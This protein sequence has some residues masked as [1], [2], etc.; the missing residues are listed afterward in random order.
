MKDIEWAVG[1]SGEKLKCARWVVG[2]ERD[3]KKERKRSISKIFEVPV[4]FKDGAI[5]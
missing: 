4:R 1:R 2:H 3:D 5:T